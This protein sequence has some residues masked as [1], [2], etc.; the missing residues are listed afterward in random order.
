M[1]KKSELESYLKMI[2]EIQAEYPQVADRLEEL[3]N[4]M[5]EDYN[6]FVYREVER[7]KFQRREQYKDF[8]EKE[9]Y[10]KIEALEPNEFIVVMLADKVAYRQAKAAVSAHYDD[11]EFSMRFTKG[12]GT[13]L[14]RTK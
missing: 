6:S 1:A 8:L 7:Q 5:Q 11:R 4:K 13:I 14:T 3:A 2:E 12:V 9:E 10:K